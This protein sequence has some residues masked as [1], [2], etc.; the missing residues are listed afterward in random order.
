FIVLSADPN[1]LY[2]AGITNAGY[3][4]LYDLRSNIMVWSLPLIKSG[5]DQ[6]WLSV[7]W[8]RD[9]I[10]AVADTFLAVVDPVTEKCIVAV[11]YQEM[12][13]L[14]LIGIRHDQFLT[15]LGIPADR[16]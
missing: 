14:E 9:C 5:R 3:L 6:V 13:S 2:M 8:W 11:E 15:A 10:L 12:A 16:G 1:G 4:R 7:W